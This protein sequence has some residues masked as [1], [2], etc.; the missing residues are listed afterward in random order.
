MRTPPAPTRTPSAGASVK[1]PWPADTFVTLAAI[2]THFDDAA[3][4]AA[5]QGGDRN[6]LDQLLRRHYDRILAVCRRIA[7]S[8]RD[9]DDACQEALIKIARN[10]RASTADRRSA[11]GR[12]G[13]PRTLRSTRFASATAAR[14]STLVEQTGS[15]P[16]SP[17]RR[18][19]E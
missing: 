2:S 3:L 9:G 15:V 13:S 5:A 19:T 1:S 10:L 7:G 12:T 14:I 17:I 6:A 4:V 16:I 11:R 18:P 8:S